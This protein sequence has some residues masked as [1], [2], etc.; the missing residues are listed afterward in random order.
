MLKSFSG[1]R[2]FTFIW[3]GQI[4]SMLGSGMTW[5]AFTV[6]AW[7]KTGHPSAL[8]AVSFFSFLP[9]A[10]LNPVAGVLVDRWNRKNVMM[11]SDFAAAIG[12]LLAMLLLVAGRLELWHVFVIAAVAGFFS[13]FQYPAYAAT[14]SSLV[15]HN[16]LGRA[17]GMMGLAYVAAGL[18][19][20]MLA[21]VLLPYVSITGIMIFDLATFVFAL[22][23][24]AFAKIPQPVVSQAGLL[25]RGRFLNELGFGF[26]YIFFKRSG[27]APLVILFVFAQFLFAI[28]TGLMAPLALGSSEKGTDVLAIIQSVGAFGGILG[29]GLMGIWGGPKRRMDGVLWAGVGAFLFGVVGL[30]FARTVWGWAIASFFFSFFEPFLIASNLALWQANVEADI[31]GKVLSARNFVVQIPYLFGLLIAGSIA[32]VP[33]VGFSLTE[34]ISMIMIFCGLAGFFVFVFGF[35]YRPLRNADTLLADHPTIQKI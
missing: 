23:I 19:A 31:Q 34:R 15:P 9:G 14:T 11:L 28:P 8:S 6:W 27:F 21:A 4:V 20:P 3:L 17:Q 33:L 26:H 30:G 13:A 24:L 12:T 2:Q 7:E 29:G 16:Q 18:F 5:F 22:S 35:L 32:E 1:M 25:S 10:L